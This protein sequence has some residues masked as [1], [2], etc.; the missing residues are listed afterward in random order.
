MRA[1]TPRGGRTR[2]TD[3]AARSISV[4]SARPA[5]RPRAP[6]APVAIAST[7]AFAVA[8]SIATLALASLAAGCEGRLDSA[9]SGPRGTTREPPGT[10]PTIPAPPMLHRLTRAEYEQTLRDLLPAGVTVPADLPNDTLLH[11]FSTVGASELTIPPLEVEQYEAAANAVAAQVLADPARRGEVFGC[12]VAA[13][14]DPCVRAFVVRFGQ[15]AWRR[16]L[17]PSEVDSIAALARDLGTMLRDPWRGAGFALSALLQSPHFL[18]RVEIGEPDPADRDRLRY[19]SWEMASRL[20]YF[21]W[22]SAPDEELLRAAAAGEL[23]SEA[24][25]TAQVDRMTADPR[26]HAAMTRFWAEFM[27][28]DRLATVSKDPTLFPTFTDTLRASMRAEIEALFTDA[29]DRDVDVREVFATD[30]SSVDP[31]LATHYG[32]DPSTLPAPGPDGRSRVTLPAS[33]RRGGVMGRAGVL[34]MWSHAT[35]SSPTFRGKFIRVN[36]LCQDIA[37]PPPGISTELPEGSGEPETLRQKLERHRTDPVCAACHDQMDPLGFTLE[38]FD[39]V[40]RWRDLDEG[41]PIDASA[42]I[43]GV[44]VDGAEELG[45]FLASSDRVGACFARRFFRWSTAHLE[46][47]GELPEIL[48]IQEAFAA[49]G[50]RVRE[51]IRIVVLSPAFRYASYPEGDCTDGETRDCSNA[52]GA[53]TQACDHGAWTAC[54]APAGTS[55]T[56]NGAD[57]DCDGSADEGVT[58]ACSTA[59]GAGVESCVAGAFAACSARAPGAETCS[60]ADEDCDGRVDEGFGAMS[61][62]G[63]YTALRGYHPLCDGAAQRIGLE[64]NMAIH[65]LCGTAAGTCGTSG[66]GPVENSGDTAVVGCVSADLRVTT[67]GDLAAQHAGCNGTTERIGPQCNAAIHRWCAA[68]GLTTGF[69]P[70][71]VSGSSVTVAC[72][73]GAE[74]VSTTYTAMSGFHGGCTASS[75]IGTDC[76]AAIHRFCSSRGAAS[77]W[78]PLENS[79]DGL[80]VACVRP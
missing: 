36:L 12:D 65:G 46:T 69:G 33:A 35:L 51:L 64:C 61:F 52:C 17:E 60:H 75:R 18:F 37:P 39:P 44:A 6:T 29:Y 47:R 41:L 27:Q 73:P 28:L 21:L 7:P 20:S 70:V 1:P 53:G 23:V 63:S 50:Y 80:A 79:G 13:E 22:G 24:G 2:A 55:E 74:T 9:P 5:R 15:R 19:T 56:C 8:L 76:N 26:A 16:P 62:A 54:S 42:V 14:G 31:E 34:T 67:Y 43:D 48:R 38:H 4:R 71:Q 30:T 72:V 78:G 3:R 77:G 40:G 45:D 11:G 58:R 49:S 68:Q 10:Q 32:L 57:D 66:F 59:C 25:L